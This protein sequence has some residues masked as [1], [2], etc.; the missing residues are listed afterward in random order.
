MN[1]EMNLELSKRIDRVRRNTLGDLLK[2]T[3]E[4]V[5]NKIAIAYKEARLTFSELDDLVNQT[6]HAFLADGMKTGDMIAVLSKNSLDF[7]I[8]NFALARIGAVMIP[9]NYMLTVQDI[10]YILNHA[11]VSGLLAAREYAHVLDEAAHSLDIRFRY[12][13]N[14]SHNQNLPSELSNWQSLAAVRQNQPAELVDFDLDDDSVAHILYTSGTESHPKGVMLTHKNIVSEYVSCIVSG[15]MSEN[16]ICIHALPLYHSA[17][18]HCFL[19]PS[20]YLGS[21][22]I[23]LDGAKPDVILETVEKEKIT[24]LF[25]PPTV[26][27]ALLRHPDFNK[28]NLST[29]EKCYYGAAIM[30][31]EV[32]KEL[33]QRLPQARFFNFYGQTEV[34]PLATV[35]KPD[36]QLRKLGS[37]GK[38]SL[39]VQTKIVDENDAEVPRGVI[40]E[41]VHRT[42]HA[43][44]GYLNEPEK[45]AEAFRNGW[46]HSGDLGVMD[47]EGYITIVDRKKDMIKTG[48]VNVSSREVEEVI[49]RIE[50]VSEVA[51]IAI[52]DPYWIE[53]VTAIIVPKIGAEL[54]KEDILNYCK[55]NLSKFKVPKYIEFTNELPKN[56]SGKLLKR[57][58]REQYKDISLKEKKE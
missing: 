44:K 22:G 7:V 18:L 43:M 53:A 21:S 47:E 57:A 40:G 39:N 12:I 4:R 51:V 29:L 9:L 38:P 20:I 1:T 58:L 52:P 48:G 31:M 55:E 56:P 27:I 3:R 36:D 6:A 16:D 11:G 46:F 32:L 15:E 54:K 33:S 8:V 30:P 19:G 17:Q 23:I 28:R 5:P 25:C 2:R 14:E 10:E 45:T 24:Q 42:P 26:W 49:Y 37:A 34:A 41:I 35:L 13:M 50:G